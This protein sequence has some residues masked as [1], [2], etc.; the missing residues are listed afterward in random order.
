MA[1]VAPKGVAEVYA[2]ALHVAR[3]LLYPPI[4][5]TLQCKIVH[6][7]AAIVFNNLRCRRRAD[8]GVT[9]RESLYR[10]LQKW[11]A[12]VDQ[13]NTGR[14]LP[15]PTNIVTHQICRP[16]GGLEGS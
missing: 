2:Q 7:L 10:L 1:Q 13:Y 5:K 12:N 15:Y 9:R 3:R 4:T 14:L 16:N 6:R 11:C 8:G